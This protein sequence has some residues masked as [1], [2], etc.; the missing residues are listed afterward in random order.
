MLYEMATGTIPYDA[1]TPFAIVLSHISEPLPLPSK[2]DPNI[3]EEVERVI[4]KSMSKD[5]DDR[6]QTAGA[7]AKELCSAL[8]LANGDTLHSTPLETVASLPKV[9]EIVP[10]AASPISREAIPVVP[11]PTTR[12]AAPTKAASPARE[13]IFHRTVGFL[14]RAV[15]FR[16]RDE[17]ATPEAVDQSITQQQKAASVAETISNLRLDAAVPAQVRLERTF[18][19]AVAVRQLSSAVLS[20]PDLTEVRSGSV[21]VSWPE[22]E[23]FIHL[24]VQVSAPECEIYGTDTY[25][26]R[27][28][29]SQDSPVFY[30]HLT[31]KSLGEI[32]IIVTVY[33]EDDWLGSARIHTVAQEQVVGKVKVQFTSEAVSTKPDDERESLRRQLAQRRSNLLKLQEQA[34]LYGAGEVPLHML[35]QIE[36]EEQAIVEIE[37]KLV[38]L[39]G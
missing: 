21:Q 6:Y 23:S 34:A 36:A 12:E 31:P 32:S 7:M 26:F 37:A 8:G 17:T 20:E 3:P 22:S 11:D 24:R 18:D 29:S 35:N 38:E 13:S 2:I 1:D 9:Q 10:P 15:Q 4:L 25:S 33:Q 27:L 14:Q 16:R 19:L 39:E 5:Q 30:F 28:Y